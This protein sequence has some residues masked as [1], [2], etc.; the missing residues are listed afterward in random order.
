MDM[1]TAFEV[2]KAKKK[3]YIVLMFIHAQLLNGLNLEVLVAQLWFYIK[4]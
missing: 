1:V 3:R 2:T 4:I